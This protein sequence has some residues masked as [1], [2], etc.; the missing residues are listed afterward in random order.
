MA[1]NPS[2]ERLLELLLSSPRQEHDFY[3]DA[4]WELSSERHDG[5]S[6]RPIPVSKIEAYSEKPILRL[7]LRE[8][9][10]FKRIIRELDNAYL[11]IEA[12]RAKASTKGTKKGG[13]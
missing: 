3:Y 13:K 8:Q 12:E 5:M 1:A 6:A 7:T 10:A 4:F 9:W 2:D 11:T